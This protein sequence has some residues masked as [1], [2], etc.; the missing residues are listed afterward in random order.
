M[1][2]KQSKH[3][4]IL[5]E[6]EDDKTMQ[7]RLIKKINKIS[8]D[9]LLETKTKDILLFLDPEYCNKIMYIITNILSDS[10]TKNKL[11]IIHG[12]IKNIKEIQEGIIDL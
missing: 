7:E 6:N 3:K 4:K 5:K 9:L 12:Y 2:A 1:G 8:A 11:Q 10:Y